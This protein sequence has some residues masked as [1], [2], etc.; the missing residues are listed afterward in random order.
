MPIIKNEK[1]ILND[2]GIFISF[3]AYSNIKIVSYELSSGFNIS[4]PAHKI[5]V[6]FDHTL[7]TQIQL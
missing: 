2:K 1:V 3:S 5:V 6:D 4:M 7:T